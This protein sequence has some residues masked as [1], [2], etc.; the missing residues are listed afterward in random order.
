MYDQTSTIDGQRTEIATPASVRSIATELRAQVAELEAGRWSGEQAGAAMDAFDE[1][2]RVAAV[3]RL[4]AAER[5]AESGEWRRRGDKSAAEAIARRTMR[6]F[7]EVK[8]DLATAAS[9]ADVPAFD[10]VVRSGEVSQ[11]AAREITPAMALDEAALPGLVRCAR[12]RGFAALRQQVAEVFARCEDG[13]QRRR[14]ARAARSWRSGTDK[15]GIWRASVAGPITDGALIEKL[16][17]LHQQHVFDEARAGGQKEPFEAYR[18]DALV[19]ALGLSVTDHAKSSAEPA[20]PADGGATDEPAGS[21]TE[22]ATEAPVAPM[23]A[24]C[25]PPAP[26]VARPRVA[27]SA[28]RHAILVRVDWTALLRGCAAPGEVCEVDGLGPISVEDVLA[29][30]ADDDPIVKALLVNG[31]DVTRLATLDRNLKDDLRLAVRERDQGCAVPGCERR[32]FVDLDHE[33]EYSSDGPTSYENLRPL[34]RWHHRL[35]TNEGFD[36]RGPVGWRQWVA[37][38]GTVLGSEEEASVRDREADP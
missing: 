6:T 8:G 22:R 24:P 15:D 38:D 37:R 4:L 25:A 36:L 11:A 18:F 32:R 34:C 13:T 12:G 2:A 10:E 3:G 16:L 28:I 30:L 23:A 9:M 7:H 14:R 17:D 26:L 27:R 21:M 19:R 31:R 5:F 33:Q 29:M 1:L 20:A 35:R